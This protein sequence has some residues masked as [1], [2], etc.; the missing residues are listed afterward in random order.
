MKDILVGL[1]LCSKTV[2]WADVPFAYSC[3]AT[4][5]RKKQEYLDKTT[6]NL[7]ENAQPTKEMSGKKT[8]MMEM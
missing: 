4:K 2:S 5:M 7:L 6:H 3:T 8:K 1:N